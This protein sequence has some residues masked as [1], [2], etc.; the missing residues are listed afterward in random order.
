LP[1]DCSDC[2]NYPFDKFKSL[3]EQIQLPLD[4]ETTIKLINLSPPIDTGAF[5]LEWTLVHLVEKYKKYDEDFEEIIE[6]SEES[7]VK[8]MLKKRLQNYLENHN[9]KK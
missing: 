3:V 5:G 1:D 4:L 7:E 6:Q 8:E 9:I 2:G